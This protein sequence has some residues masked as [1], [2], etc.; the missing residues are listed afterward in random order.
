MY[1]TLVREKKSGKTKPPPLF[2]AVGKMIKTNNNSVFFFLMP[3]RHT[4]DRVM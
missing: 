2:G 1:G 3:P 4:S